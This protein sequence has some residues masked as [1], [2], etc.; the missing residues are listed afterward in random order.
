MAI[1]NI[2][3]IRDN[4]VSTFDKPFI[5]VS[6][7]HATRQLNVAVNDRQCQLAMFPEDFDLYRLGSID[8][9]TGVVTPESTPKF[10]IAAVSVRKNYQ[11]QDAIN[12]LAET[13]KG[14]QK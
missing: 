11:N 1:L 4:K 3:S 6:D 12:A 7:I 14:G 5:D 13:L 8:D 2:Y 10:I 9:Q